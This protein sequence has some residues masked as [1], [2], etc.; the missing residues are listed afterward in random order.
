MVPPEHRHLF[1]DIPG[2][3]CAVH[4]SPL[5][6]L[7]THLFPLGRNVLV[8]NFRAERSWAFV[9]DE[10]HFDNELLVAAR[11]LELRVGSVAL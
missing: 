10:A 2:T 3:G 8:T 9:N 11:D 4:S 7:A 6:L 1:F 5:N